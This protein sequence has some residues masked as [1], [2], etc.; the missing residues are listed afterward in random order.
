MKWD[1]TVE[2]RYSIHDIV[3][4]LNTSHSWTGVTIECCLVSRCLDILPRT[5]KCLVVKRHQRRV[6]S[7]AFIWFTRPN[8]ILFVLK[9]LQLYL[10]GQLSYRRRFQ[11]KKQCNV[12]VFEYKL[13]AI[14]FIK[15][16]LI[17]SDLFRCFTKH[18]IRVRLMRPRK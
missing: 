2:T 7:N 1:K 15:N 6:I 16:K 10:F 14:Q 9:Q 3:H 4:L 5:I 17:N 11:Q 18:R 12:N 13:L 8:N